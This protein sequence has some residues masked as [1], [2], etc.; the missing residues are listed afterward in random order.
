MDKFAYIAAHAAVNT[1]YAQQINSHNIANMNTTGFKMDLDY[2]DSLP[3]YG[4][5]APTRAY[6]E[7]T[8]KGFSDE[9]GTLSVTGGTFDFGIK[10]DGW[11]TVQSSETGTIGYTRRGDFD[12][13]HFG[14]LRN[15]DGH[16]LVGQGGSV[17]L[18]PHEK[19]LIANDGT[20]SIQPAGASSNE[21]A[22]LDRIN[23][24]NPPAS[25]LRKSSEGMFV[26]KDGEEAALDASV[27]MRSGYLES[28]NVN[29]TE[30]MIEMIEHARAFQVQVSFMKKAEELDASVSKLLSSN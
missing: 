17:V 5:G 21:V 8:Q 2:F 9:K 26:R 16:M 29:S 30:T 28:S 6:S 18:P 22:A 14:I 11:F 13:D 15:G 24:V 27:S 19:V 10:G 25:E 12:L 23:L 20:I 3:V 7:E 1:M 4:P